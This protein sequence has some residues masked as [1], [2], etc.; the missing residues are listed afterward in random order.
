MGECEVIMPQIR[1]V[2]EG[3]KH[4]ALCEG[5]C[6]HSYAGW[7]LGVAPEVLWYDV[8][9]VGDY[10]GAVYGVGRYRSQILLY[11]DY[12]GSCSGCGAWGEGGEP[13]SLKEVLANSNLFMLR[14]GAV[15][16]VEGNWATMYNSPD[17]DQVI[18]AIDE[19]LN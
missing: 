14:S 3:D 13:S 11:E 2:V 5:Y 4:T 18:G 19:V 10:Q 16:Y 17:I 7:L 9:D 15:S 6:G 8:Q 1:V 12:Y